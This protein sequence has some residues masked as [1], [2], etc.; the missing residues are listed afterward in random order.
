MSRII[1]CPVE[2][3][4]PMR[5]PET[6]YIAPLPHEQDASIRAV[7]AAARRTKWAATHV[8]GIRVNDPLEMT[9]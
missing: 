7:V 4:L 3:A 6:V 9:P 8:L 5:A 1:C 2:P